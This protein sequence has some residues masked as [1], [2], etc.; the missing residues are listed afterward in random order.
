MCSSDLATSAVDSETEFRIGE[1][2]S[3]I[4]EDL[5]VITIAHRLT[6]VRSMNTVLVLDDGRIAASGSFGEVS[7]TSAIFARWVELNQLDPTR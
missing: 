4:P 7:R 2:I 3:A 6:T 1:A 5:T